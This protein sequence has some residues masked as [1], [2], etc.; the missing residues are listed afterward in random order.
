M[1]CLK[2]LN[3]FEGLYTVQL[4]HSMTILYIAFRYIIT[5][6]NNVLHCF[7]FTAG[8]EKS[9]HGV[10]NSRVKTKDLELVS[11]VNLLL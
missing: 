4:I 10:I 9:W 6:L 1:V 2:V 11:D 8:R 7:G 5:K 3:Q